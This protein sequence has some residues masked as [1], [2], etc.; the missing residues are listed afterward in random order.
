MDVISFWCL[1]VAGFLPIVCA[2]ISKTDKSYDNSN[3]R[4]WLGNQGGYR[5]RAN[6]AQLN[7]WESFIW[8]SVSIILTLIHGPSDTEIVNTFS[9]LFIFFRVF[10]I[11]FYVLDLSTLRTI[12]WLFGQA[13]VVTI[14]FS[15]V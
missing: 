13:C 4:K 10:Y 9:V 2:G 12:A 7:S 1:F 15:V 8:F 3:P 5:E 6:A 14:F 11:G